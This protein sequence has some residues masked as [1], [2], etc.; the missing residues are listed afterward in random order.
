MNAEQ[1]QETDIAIARRLG[2]R[3]EHLPGGWRSKSPT[4]NT[5]ALRFATDE[6]EAWVEAHDEYILPHFTDSLDAVVAALA[7]NY[8]IS[9][10]GNLEG[11]YYA[12]IYE[13]KPPLGY[14]A[15]WT[16]KGDTRAEAAAL[17][18]RALLDAAE[19]GR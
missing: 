12:T 10:R 3:V 1:R 9:I 2:W 11:G 17:A 6:R 18:L 15:Q 5:N 4:D 14:Q 19:E 16:G 8:D 13:D 7:H